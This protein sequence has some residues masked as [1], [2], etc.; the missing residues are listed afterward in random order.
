MSHT[1][2][3]SHL[4]LLLL[5]LRFGSTRLASPLMRFRFRLRLVQRP[6]RS[7]TWQCGKKFTLFLHHHGSRPERRLKT[8]EITIGRA[9]VSRQGPTDSNSCS[10][11]GRAKAKT[12][13]TTI[14]RVIGTWEESRMQT[15][16]QAKCTNDNSKRDGPFFSKRQKSREASPALRR[17]DVLHSCTSKRFK[18]GGK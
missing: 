15:G 10:C 9:N 18:R 7:T 17:G 8:K 6:S 13:T 2:S 12:K 16:L 1:R 14:M 3:H 4:L 11:Q 5:R